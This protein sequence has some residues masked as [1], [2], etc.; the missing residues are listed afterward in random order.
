MCD[1][2]KVMHIAK[3]YI[4]YKIGVIGVRIYKIGSQSLDFTGFFALRFSFSLALRFFLRLKEIKAF[5]TVMPL[6]HQNQTVLP[7]QGLLVATRLQAADPV[8][9]LLPLRQ[10]GLPA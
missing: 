4:A 2:R 7:H 8:L 10:A 6:I 3:I 5:S 9:P 1:T